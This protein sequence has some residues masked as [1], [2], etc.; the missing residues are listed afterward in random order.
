MSKFITV[1]RS[2]AAD[3]SGATYSEYV[4]LCVLIGLVCIGVVTVIGNGVHK[5][6]DGV[7]PVGS[8]AEPPT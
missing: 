1:A 5:F 2:F 6:F 7:P 4:V 3:E 8:S